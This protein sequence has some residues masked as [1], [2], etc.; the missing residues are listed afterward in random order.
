M[1]RR[2]RRKKHRQ[3]CDDAITDLAFYHPKDQY[4]R[5][6]PRTGVPFEPFS[7]R[8]QRRFR[9][10]SLSYRVFCLDNDNGEVVNLWIYPSEFPLAGKH[11]CVFDWK[12][13]VD[14]D[15]DESSVADEIDSQ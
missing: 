14:E 5:L 7:D 4:L 11:L 3:L 9:R 2:L 15:D 12:A 13:V 1:N 8:V 10:W 6:A